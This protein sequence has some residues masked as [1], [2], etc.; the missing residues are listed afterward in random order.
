M[1]PQSAFAAEVMQH[2]TLTRRTAFARTA[3]MPAR[4]CCTNG[5]V[6]GSWEGT[7]GSAQFCMHVLH[8]NATASCSTHVDSIVVQ[9]TAHTCDCSRQV[10]QWAL[11]NAGFERA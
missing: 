7:A 5:V 10:T 11:S 6:D 1:I 8:W 9:R 3:S 2:N 4:W